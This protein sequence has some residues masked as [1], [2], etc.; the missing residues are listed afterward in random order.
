MLTPYRL[1]PTSAEI[2]G[3]TSSCAISL[4][5]Q[6][7]LSNNVQPAYALGQ[8]IG[9]MLG[10]CDQYGQPTEFSYPLDRFVNYI[11]GKCTDLV[12]SAS[13]IPEKIHASYA[14]VLHAFIKSK[15]NEASLSTT[16]NTQTNTESLISERIDA[17][18]LR[19]Q[20]EIVTFRL[21]IQD[22]I[23]AAR[24]KEKPLLLLLGESHF[25]LDSALMETLILQITSELDGFPFQHVFTEHFESDIYQLPDNIPYPIVLLGQMMH[26]LQKK[27]IP[28]DLATCDIFETQ[29]PEVCQIIDTDQITSGKPI[30]LDNVTSVSSMKKRNQVMA[31]VMNAFK[32]YGN[33]IAVVGRDH[34]FGIMTETTLNESYHVVPVTLS[35]HMLDATFKPHAPNENSLCE[36]AYQEACFNYIFDKNVLQLAPTLGFS[37]FF[38][39]PYPSENIIQKT[40]QAALDSRQANRLRID[41]QR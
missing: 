35:S 4:S 27:K 1:T 30:H 24:A 40:K 21:A 17:A 16:I 33:A 25:S 20:A 39:E 37:E 9:Q 6:F 29:K 23:D 36:D 26:A 19:M 8:S 32:H 15:N 34:L 7:S 3:N 28:M 11:Y 12:K 13:R 14:L 18:L 41:S 5:S 38:T 31:H 22:A 2:S 10:T